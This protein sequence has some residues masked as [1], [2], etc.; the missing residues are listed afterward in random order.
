MFI[1]F[2]AYSF[3]ICCRS[4]YQ[5]SSIRCQRCGIVC[6]S[7]CPGFPVPVIPMSVCKTCCCGPR[8]YIDQ[9]M[10]RHSFC[11]RC[12]PRRSCKSL[13]I[14]FCRF[15]IRCRPSRCCCGSGCCCCGSG[16]LPSVII[17]IVLIR[18]IVAFHFFSAACSCSVCFCIRSRLRR[19]SLQRFPFRFRSSPSV[20][21]CHAERADHTQIQFV[22]FNITHRPRPPFLLPPPPGSRLYS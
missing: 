5:K 2:V 20:F 22:P 1:Q 16:S 12:R 21:L 6:T 4:G 14:Y 8:K 3:G 11:R 15:S 18:R 19:S 17:R 9:I 10:V 13:R 7:V